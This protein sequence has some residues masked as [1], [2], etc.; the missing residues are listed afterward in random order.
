LRFLFI[1]GMNIPCIL[2]VRTRVETVDSG[3]H[4]FWETLS[5]SVP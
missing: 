4:F 3:D 1:S 5:S 2:T